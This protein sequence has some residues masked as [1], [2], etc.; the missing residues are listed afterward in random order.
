[1]RW[2]EA[3]R[4]GMA[5][6]PLTRYSIFS[7]G[8]FKFNDNVSAFIQGNL[9]SFSGEPDSGLRAGHQLLGRIRCRGMPHTRCRRS[10]RRS[11]TRVP[12]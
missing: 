6:S 5:S 2:G 10:S 8:T 12:T 1:M 3:D 4:T 9:S 7:R 11:S